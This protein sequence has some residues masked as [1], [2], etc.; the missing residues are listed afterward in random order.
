MR[1]VLLPD[2]TSRAGVVSDGEQSHGP[3]IVRVGMCEERMSTQRGEVSECFAV[4]C[5]LQRDRMSDLRFGRSVR[6]WRNLRRNKKYATHLEKKNTREQVRKEAQEAA[7][8]PKQPVVKS[9]PFSVRIA[10]RR[11][12]LLWFESNCLMCR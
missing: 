1:C 12:R 9:N 7:K 8:A 3:S 11:T 4:L 2:G 10:K 5:A 6:A